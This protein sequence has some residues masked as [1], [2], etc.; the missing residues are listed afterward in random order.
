MTASL[1]TAIDGWRAREMSREHAWAEQYV[2]SVACTR[3]V[4]AGDDE[5]PVWHN[6]R[7]AEPWA[8]PRRRGRRNASQRG[9]PS[10]TG[11]CTHLGERGKRIS[12]I[13]KFDFCACARFLKQAIVRGRA[14]PPGRVRA[15]SGHNATDCNTASLTTDGKI[16]IYFILKTKATSTIGS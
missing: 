7:A 14:S 13:K 8:S 4:A 10:V 6:K 2:T 11:T 1:R 12:G 5:G 16:E 15:S 9:C 3:Q